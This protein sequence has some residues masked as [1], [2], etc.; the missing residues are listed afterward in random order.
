MPRHSNPLLGL[1]LALVS[2]T[3]LSRL[4]RELEKGNRSRGGS[5]VAVMKRFLV[6]AV[7]LAIVAAACAQPGDA[8]S[9]SVETPDGNWI[10]VSGVPIVDGGPI[11]LSFTGEEFGGR[12]ACNTYGGTATITGDSIEMPGATFFMTEM[13]CQADIQ[14]SESA[15]VAALFE[16][17]DWSVENRQLTLTGQGVSLVFEPVADVPTAAIV[18]TNWVL[19]SLV[20]GEA[21]SS[22]SGNPTLLLSEIGTVAG[23]TGCRELSGTW[24]VGGGEIFFPE[25]SASGECTDELRAQ[26]GLIVT[27][28]GDGFVAE[29]AGDRLEITDVSGEGLV[30]RS[31]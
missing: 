10:L 16:V 19:E 8:G 2:A 21:V 7:G 20:S 9:S 22:V 3:R 28:L 30:Y 5:V 29:V 11:T 14:A 1:V 12:A 24:V 18:G 25:L 17:S 4:V 31:Q 6:L 23:S 27:V 13:G 15:F 26:D